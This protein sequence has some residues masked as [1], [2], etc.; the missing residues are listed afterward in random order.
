VAG[1]VVSLDLRRLYLHNLRL[2]GSSMH[3]RAHFAKLVDVAR[4]GSVAPRIAGRHTL[5]DIH[6]A[7]EQFLERQHIGKIVITPT[8]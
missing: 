3:T 5:A 6:Q 8:V 4:T 7:Q 1:P 2:I